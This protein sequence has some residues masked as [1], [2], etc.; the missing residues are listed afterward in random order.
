MKLNNVFITSI[1]GLELF[2]LPSGWATHISILTEAG[3][4]FTYT[5]PNNSNKL[6]PVA[7]PALP[8][9]V[10]PPPAWAKPVNDDDT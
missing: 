10:Q 3:S 7:L 5:E 8:I 6:F 9:W 2:N 1:L 4:G